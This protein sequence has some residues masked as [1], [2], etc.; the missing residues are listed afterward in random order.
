MTIMSNYNPADSQDF[1][2]IF[3]RKVNTKKLH[4]HNVA[5]YLYFLV[6]ADLYFL[7]SLHSFQQSL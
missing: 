4:L 1:Q 3:R 5:V 7:R 2:S 6:F